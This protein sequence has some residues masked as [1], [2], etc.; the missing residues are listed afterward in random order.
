MTRPP[1]DKFDFEYFESLKIDREAAIEK[2][3]K[4]LPP[5]LRR[6]DEELNAA[7]AAAAQDY[8]NEK[9]PPG[10]PASAAVAAITAA[11]AKC[12]FGKYDRFR[13][14]TPSQYFYHCKYIRSGHGMMAL[15]SVVE[16][17]VVIYTDQDGALIKA[18]LVGRAATGL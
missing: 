3:S 8:L 4:T 9:F 2:F 13:S 15:V 7:H 5:S 17:T 1:P 11:G 16:W 18:I 6:P 10:T 14:N 12:S